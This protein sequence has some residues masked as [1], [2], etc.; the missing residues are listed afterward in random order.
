VGFGY[1]SGTETAEVPGNA[2]AFN[3]LV[4]FQGW[5]VEGSNYWYAMAVTPGQASTVPVP[6]AAWL[7]GSGLLG[8][9]GIARRR[10][11]PPIDPAA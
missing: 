5:S 9:V 10:P 6:G 1:W 8:L 7:L 3:T 4:G 2:W 11:A